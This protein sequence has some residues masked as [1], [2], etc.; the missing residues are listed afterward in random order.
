MYE[1]VSAILYSI[2]EYRLITS[3]INI[4]STSTTQMHPLLIYPKI[5]LSQTKVTNL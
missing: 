2:Q 5:K 4:I 1:K 3:M